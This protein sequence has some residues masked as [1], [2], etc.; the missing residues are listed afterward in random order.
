MNQT[1]IL[2]K[3]TRE[4][5]EYE[6]REL[7]NENKSKKIAIFHKDK[8]LREVVIPI[9]TETDRAANGVTQ[10]QLA[11]LALENDVKSGKL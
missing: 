5:K 11:I 6:I 10:F 4:N 3:L 9:G 1:P 2:K 7:P 8:K